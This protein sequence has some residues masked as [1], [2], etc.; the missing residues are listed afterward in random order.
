MELYCELPSGDIEKSS[1]VLCGFAKTKLLNKGESD[2]VTIEFDPYLV[3]SYD[4][5]DADN[6]GKKCYTLE[7]GLY[8]LCLKQDSHN[9]KI[10]VNPI[11]VEIGETVHYEQDPHTN[12]DVV[13]RFDDAD[14]QLDTLLSRTDWN[15]T[16]P[17][18]AT[19]REITSELL[20]SLSSTKT[21]NPTT[22]YEMPKMGVESD[23][24][25]TDLRGLDYDDPKWYELLDSLTF[26][27][28]K[29]I[30]N[31]GAFKTHGIIRIGLP[32]TS[33][34]DGPA[35]FT[36]F[37]SEANVSGNVSYACQYV[38]GSTWNVELAKA[39]GESV[40]EEAAWGNGESIPTPYTGW[41]APGV[42][43]HRSPFGGRN[44]EYYSEDPI[45]SG[46]M[47]AGVISGAESKGVITYMKH[48]AL[49][50]QET[51]RDMNGVATWASEQAIREL[52][53]KPFE[54]AVKYGGASGVMSS[55]NRIGSVWTGGDYRLLTEVLRNEWGFEGAVICDF[56][57]SSYM[58]PKQMVYAGGDLN[59]TTMRYWMRPDETDAG[60]VT[61]LRNAAHNVLYN[62]IN[63]N[64]MNGLDENT[65]L[66]MSTP[67]WQTIMYAIEVAIGA[68]LLLWGL[69]GVLFSR[70]RS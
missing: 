8:A 24:V 40:G 13:N 47:A 65:Q 14:D 31:R 42:N 21:N 10:G 22:D 66:H 1:V 54:I 59:L 2:T 5:Y 56:N 34:S 11:V 15:G 29:N 58:S 7:D 3:S 68:I 48:F 9:A 52:Y 39:M 60:D 25:A 41:Y 53:F 51:Y 57:V 26:D 70:K 50:E 32:E 36:N 67:M 69:F 44:Y 19:N 20:A 62:V 16:Y 49:N 35:G 27:E 37:M 17:Q 38:V 33:A 28:L 64:A 43:L 18:S 4:C 23:I 30:F 61:A 45:L 6:D 12:A 55:F 46:F 63:S